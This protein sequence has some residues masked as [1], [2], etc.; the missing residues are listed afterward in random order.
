M[1]R[2]VLNFKRIPLGLIILTAVT[3]L[4]IN[5]H[6]EVAALNVTGDKNYSEAWKVLDIVNEHRTAEGLNPLTMD[7]VLLDAAMLRAAEC[8][9]YY[10]HDRP[11]NTQCF[12]VVDWRNSVGENLAVMN[13]ITD[14]SEAVNNWMNSPGH[15]E[16]IMASKFSS[17]GVGVFEVDGIQYWAQLFDGG[18]A[19]SA[20]NLSGSEMVTYS[21]EADSSKISLVTEQN[22][23]VRFSCEN[24]FSGAAFAVDEIYNANAGWGYAYININKNSLSYQSSDTGV[25]TVGDDGVI[26]PV[27]LGKAEVSVFMSG[28]PNQALAYNITVGDHEFALS[29]SNKDPTCV[30]SGEA[31][32]TCVTCGTTE[33]RETAATGKH[34]YDSGVITKEPTAADNGVLTYTCV[35]CG[36]VYIEEIAATV[37]IEET[38]RQSRI[39]ELTEINIDPPPLAAEV[40]EKSVTEAVTEE[41]IYTQP[42][43]T[44]KPE[45]ESV[46]PTPMTANPIGNSEPEETVISENNETD[47]FSAAI[48]IAVCII[49]AALMIIIVI[50]I[51]K[52]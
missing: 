50:I 23:D 38:Q 12:T 11:N 47:Q 19:R 8:A 39:T 49:S 42:E 35:I 20:G 36:A 21:V 26:I 16:N 30:D 28:F 33:I 6:G 7:S 22:T 4:T 2:S 51:R 13:Y 34:S 10:S 45:I 44:V 1:N 14:A 17:I 25:V 15:K 48:I 52:R 18:E 27:A 3:L 31:V 46:S 41:I 24:P 9:V 43:T 40:D 32:Y 37:H 5:I 29:K